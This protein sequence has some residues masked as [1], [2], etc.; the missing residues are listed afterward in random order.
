[1]S[2]INK[3]FNLKNKVAVITGGAG[4]LGSEYGKTLAAAGANIVLVDLDQGRCKDRAQEIEKEF[5]VKTTGIK[6]DISQKDEVENMAKVIEDRFGRA[7]ILINNAAFNCPASEAASCF[8]DFSDYPLELWEKSL[9][10][11]LTGAFLCTQKIIKIMIK[12]D[13]KGSIINIASTYGVV[14][15]DQRLY[16]NIKLPED[17]T[18]RFIKPV[19]YSTTKSAILNFTRYLAALYG[20]KGI[21]VNTLTPGGVFDNQEENFVKEYCKRTPLGRMAKKDDYNGAIL[22]LASDASKYMTGANLV[23]DGGWTCW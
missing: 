5:G 7:D 3:L 1:M 17:K 2:N 15:P 20:D 14:A 16:T 22:F 23:V 6:A 18:K 9:G 19:D 11:N 21:R 13:I 12:N 10:V 8:N 4:M